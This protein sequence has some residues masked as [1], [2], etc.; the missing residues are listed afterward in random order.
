MTETDNH[1]VQTWVEAICL[2][3]KGSACCRYLTMGAGGFECAKHT[4]LRDTIDRRVEAGS[5]TA[6]GDNCKGLGLRKQGE[7]FDAKEVN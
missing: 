4:N 3:G 7:L 1:I 6:R 2:I 5:F